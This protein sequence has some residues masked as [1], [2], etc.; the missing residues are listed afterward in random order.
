M[1]KPLWVAVAV[2]GLTGVCLAATDWD[3]FGYKPKDGFVPDENAAIAI[4]V[5]VWTP[6][7]GAKAIADEKPYRA[8]LE[9]EVWRVEGSLPEGWRG[10]PATA[11]I[12]KTDGRVRAVWHGQ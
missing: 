12:E 2:L 8:R 10:G 11:I 7:Y 1:K 9:G 6:I 5:A 3:H 4:A